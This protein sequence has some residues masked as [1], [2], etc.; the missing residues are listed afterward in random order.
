[1]AKIELPD[2]MTT[3]LVQ[4]AYRRAQY[5]Q[6]RARHHRDDR[7]LK[8]W[9]IRGVRAARNRDARMLL[10]LEKGAEVIR[11]LNDDQQARFAAN[12]EG[13]E[14]QRQDFTEFS[15]WRSAFELADK[16]DPSAQHGIFGWIYGAALEA[17]TY[18][19]RRHDASFR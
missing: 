9:M 6:D 2:F 5:A 11:I 19:R 13:V 17:C 14:F 15:I 18:G 4:A 1:M 10:F 12:E 7:A 16:P 8:E 3:E